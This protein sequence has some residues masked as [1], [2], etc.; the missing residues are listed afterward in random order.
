MKK[1]KH[2]F[3]VDNKYVLHKLKIL[4]L[5]FLHKNWAR[6][7]NNAAPGGGLDDG[8]GGG[9]SGSGGLPF[10]SPKEDI[11]A[12]DLYIPTMAFLTYIIFCSFAMGVNG[13][14][15]PDVFGRTASSGTCSCFLFFPVF[16]C[17]FVFLWGGGLR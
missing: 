16:L 2:Y 12:P 14:F 9:G 1:L 7:P 3:H 10:R 4:A 17:L 15:T 8:A 5:P 6:L 13:Q 11:N